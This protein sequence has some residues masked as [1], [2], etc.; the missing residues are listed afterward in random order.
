MWFV[1]CALRVVRLSGGSTRGDGDLNVVEKGFQELKYDSSVFPIRYG[2]DMRIETYTI[3]A[4]YEY[5]FVSILQ[6]ILKDG[7]GNRMAADVFWVQT[8]S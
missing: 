2:E 7:Y 1:T 4:V 6:A 3:F 5:S 8:L